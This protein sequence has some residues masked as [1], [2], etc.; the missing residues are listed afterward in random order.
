MTTA[1]LHLELYPKQIELYRLIEKSKS[2]WIGYG[3]SR[4]G[5]KSG[6]L[7]RIMLA[8]RFSHPGTWGII[9]RRV[10]DELK[11]NHIDELFREYPNLKQYY[12]VGDKELTLPDTNGSKIFFGYAETLD[13]VKRKFMGGQYMDVFVDQAEQFYRTRASRNQASR[14]LAWVS[15]GRLQIHD[16]L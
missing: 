7:R 9:V 12:K 8:R 5:G 14:A 2:S 16:V 10:F 3:G 11:R 6:A 1:D 4:G 13:E 15:G